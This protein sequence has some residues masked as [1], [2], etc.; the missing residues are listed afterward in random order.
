MKTSIFNGLNTGTLEFDY[1]I[2]YRPRIKVSPNNTIRQT[3]YLFNNVEYD[4]IYFVWERDST[5]NL[6]HSHNLIKTIDDDLIIKLKQNI[7]SNKEPKE[8]VRQVTIRRDKCFTN[9]RT[10]E[11]ECKPVDSI[12]SVVGYT[13]NGKHGEVFI[14][15]IKSVRASAIYIN[16][17]TDRGLNFDYIKAT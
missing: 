15:P 14:E 7:I 10:G 2:R 9:I 16:K 4:H 5:S 3:E 17:Y 12:E 8:D 6:F 1:C 11:R 13:M